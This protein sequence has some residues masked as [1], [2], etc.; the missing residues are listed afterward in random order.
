MLEDY[1]KI[2]VKASRVQLP[3]EAT[4]PEVDQL[5]AVRLAVSGI[6]F[7]HTLRADGQNDEHIRRLAEAEAN[8][9]PI[10]VHRPSM[11]VIDGNHR[12]RA[13]ELRGEEYIWARLFEGDDAAAF[14][15]GVSL[16]VSH[17]L[18]LTLTDRKA[19][20]ARIIQAHPQWSD[21]SIATLTG[22]A[23]KTVA[24]VR[25]KAVGTHHQVHGRLGRDGRVRPVDRTSRRAAAVQLLTKD[26][27][28]S[29]RSVAAEVGLSPETVRDVRARLQR[30]EDPTSRRRPTT[31]SAKVEMPETSAP[32]NA[33][34]RTTAPSL[35]SGQVVGLDPTRSARGGA[36]RAAGVDAL[37]ADPTLRYRES[38]R[39]LI[40][41]LEAHRLSDETWQRLL[42]TVPYH[43][44]GIVA[45]TA[46]ACAQQWL[47]FA[48]EVSRRDS[49]GSI[50]H[51]AS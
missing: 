22:L 20:A 51:P 3:H 17:G 15:L 45:K 30:G 14:V 21:R 26:P 47:R 43:C 32:V 25:A 2:E 41:L 39:A 48:D 38:G 12:L 35:G 28:T 42:E 44:A 1:H 7:S 40:R 49:A 11:Q 23:A 37:R 27:Q 19:A 46:Q 24:G 33:E 18:P 8:L 29:L 10:V 6:R 4:M 13:A 5:P 31:R 36:A 34:S 9:P 16:N 50:T